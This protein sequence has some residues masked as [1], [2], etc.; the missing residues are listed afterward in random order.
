MKKIQ[1]FRFW[2]SLTSTISSYFQIHHFTKR[3]QSAKHIV[4]SF[5]ARTSERFCSSF[6]QRY[7]AWKG[8]FA[9]LY[10]LTWV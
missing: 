1:D 8:I 4:I 7:R 6:T 3:G 2:L 5:C 10:N 9:N